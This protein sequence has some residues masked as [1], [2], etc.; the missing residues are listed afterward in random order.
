[1]ECVLEQKTVL[2]I[3]VPNIIQDTGSRLK[4]LCLI[5][6]KSGFLVKI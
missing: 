1:M 6:K 2:T 3:L 4:G 5:T